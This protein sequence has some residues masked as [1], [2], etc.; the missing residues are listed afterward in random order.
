MVTFAPE[1]VRKPA[2][3]GS[4]VYWQRG[5]LVYVLPIASAIT[6]TKDYPVAGFADWDFTPATNAFW[7][8]AVST[9]SGQ[10]VFAREKIAAGVNP[11]AQPP[12]VVTGMLVN[13]KSQQP[14]TVRLVPM[15]SSLLRH[16]VFE[17]AARAVKAASSQS[18][19]L[20]NAANLARKAEV[21][22][23]N[24]ARGYQRTALV[25]GVAEGFPDNQGAEWASD[26]GGVGTKVRLVWEMPEAVE[27]IWLFDRPNPADHVLAATIK[28]S[29]GSTAEVGELPN[30]GAT[31]LR[32]KFPTKTI[33]WMEVTI[34]KVGPKQRNAGFSEIAV[35]GHQ[36]VP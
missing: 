12:V 9:N 27:S 8:Y 34:T 26:R 16:T 6:K 7:D 19:L 28:F 23:A 22:A 24:T 25:D 31:P 11:W 20:K 18:E 14:E 33:T 13:R 10:F 35:F 17:D 29:D 2:A 1:I 5:P 15:G 21:V 4:G 36:P 3:D 30:N 32:L